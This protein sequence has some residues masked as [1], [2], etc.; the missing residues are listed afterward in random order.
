MGDVAAVAGAVTSITNLIGGILDRADRDGPDNELNENIIKIQNGFL[1]ADPNL[2]ELG[3]LVQ[4]LLAK[5][6]NPATP[7]RD[8]GLYRKELFHSLLISLAELIHERQ[9]AARAFAKLT[10]S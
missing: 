9:L 5:A 2:P 6:G 8:A 4:L 7:S 10:K 1:S 3:V